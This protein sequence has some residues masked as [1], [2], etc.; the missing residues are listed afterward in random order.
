[1]SKPLLQKDL[2]HIVLYGM[3]ALS[4]LKNARLFITGGTGFFGIWLVESLCY[5][6][7]QLQLN[8]KITLLSRDPIKFQKKHAHLFPNKVITFLQGDVR[9]FIFPSESFTHV[10]HAATE[11]SS[12]LN[13]RDPLMMLDVI[14]NGTKHVCDMMLKS[15]AKKNLIVSSGAV[16]GRQ[17]P[18]MSH[19]SEE[20]DG[21]PNG[22]HA[23]SAYGFGKKTAEYIALLFSKQHQLPVNI[24]RC[25]AF[26]GPHLPLDTHFAVG[27]FIQD[28]LLDRTITIAGDGTPYRSYQY[29]ADLIIWLLHILCFGESTVPYNVGSDAP[30]SILSLAEM[31]K[32]VSNKSIDIIVSKKADDTV[33]PERYV[34]SIH[35]AQNKLGLENIISLQ[36]AIARTLA[37]HQVKT[38]SRL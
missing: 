1:M 11:A 34:P 29:A 6:N 19:V 32:A 38:E 2:D 22:N 35:R 17:S 3:R 15:G 20:F 9:D 13:A 36:D 7:V 33:L 25:F 23:E 37:W 26:V 27:N 21:F 31:V 16:Y 28:V 12:I 30:I 10:I 18:A 8:L 24:A 14:M 5:A 4:T